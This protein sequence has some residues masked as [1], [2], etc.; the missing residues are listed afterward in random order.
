MVIV[1]EQVEV[2]LHASFTVQA[3]IDIPTLNVPLALSPIPF[4]VVAPDTW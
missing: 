4:L 3:I 1:V 2:L